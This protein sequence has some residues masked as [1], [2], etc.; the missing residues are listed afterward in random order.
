MYLLS[1][2]LFFLHYVLTYLA[3]LSFYLST[4]YYSLIY[5]IQ[6]WLRGYRLGGGGKD[7]GAAVYLLSRQQLQKW[8]YVDKM[9]PTELQEKYRVE[10]GVYAHRANLVQWVQV[11]MQEC[12]VGMC[13]MCSRSFCSSRYLPLI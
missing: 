2:F 10:C 5:F 9:T 6:E 1:Y 7:G 4:L 13:R 3:L 8:W 12:F 11:H